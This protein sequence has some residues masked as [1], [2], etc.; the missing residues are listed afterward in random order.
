MKFKSKIAK[1]VSK[2]V[3]TTTALVAGAANAAVDTAVST[4]LETAAVD[5]ATVGGLS[6]LAVLAAVSFKYMRRGL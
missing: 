3:V 1:G 5:V 6:F 4:G 2:A